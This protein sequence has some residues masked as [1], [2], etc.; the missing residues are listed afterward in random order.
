[1]KKIL[2]F[3]IIFLLVF[4]IMNLFNDDKQVEQKQEIVVSSLDSSYTIPA[5][6]KIDVENNRDLPLDFNTCDNFKINSAWNYISM[7]ESFCKDINLK[8]SEKIELDFSSQYSKFLNTWNYVVTANLEDKEYITTFEIDNKGTITKLFS[9]LIYAPVYNLLIFLIKTF[10]SSLGWA[11]IAITIIIRAIL[12]W[13]QHKM[14]VSQR[15]LQAIQ[16][17][18]KEIQEQYKWNHQMLG[19]KMMELYKKEKVNPMWSCGFL[20]IQM[21][22]LLVIYNIILYIKDESHYYYIYSFLSNFDI[23]SISYNFYGLDLLAKWGIV[24]IFLWLSVWVVQFIQIKLSIANN[25]TNNNNL[26]LEKKKWATDYSSMMPDP[27]T[28]NKFMLY[29]MPVMVAVFTYMFPAWLGIYWW[30]STTFMIFQQLIVNK[31][32]KTSR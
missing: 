16:P 20:L 31:K 13:P 1:M 6:I 5:S 21:P 11:I 4:L 23:S 24:W 15:K 22:I 18:I 9:S 8:A 14:M 27:E 26:V 25:K 32:I 12:L 28:M 3:I 30:I 7:D 19:M 2:D 29:G 10:N 17:K